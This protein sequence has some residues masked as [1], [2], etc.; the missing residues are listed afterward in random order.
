MVVSMLRQAQLLASPVDVEPVETSVAGN[1]ATKR[2]Q[3]L[4]VKRS[5][6]IW[7]LRC[8]DK[9]SYQRVLWSFRQAQRP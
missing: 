1:S 5:E 6:V 4:P 3:I 9:L 2:S 8:F 7:W